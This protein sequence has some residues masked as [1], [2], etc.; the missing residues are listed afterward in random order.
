MDE[1]EDDRTPAQRFAD[2]KRRSAAARTE[3]AEFQAGYE[4]GLDGFQV[5]ACELLERGHSVLVAAPTGSGKTI[6]G[7]FAIHLALQG[8]TRAFYTTPIKALSNQ[9]FRDLCERHGAANVGLLTGDSVINGDAPVVV[10]TTEVL[11]NMLYEASSAIDTLSHVVMD[12]VH[13]LADRQRGAVWEEVILHL[14]ERITLVALSATVSNAEEFGAWLSQV[15]GG[16]DVIVEERRPVPLHQHVL[17]GRNLVDLFVHPSGEDEDVS[18]ASDAALELNPELVRRAQE[19]ARATRLND[20]SRGRGRGRPRGRPQRNNYVPRAAVLERLDRAGLLPAIVFVFS[21]RGCEEAVTSCLASGV[22]LISDADRRAVRAYVDKRC[23]EIPDQ[24]LAVLGYYEWREALERGVAAHH[25][26]MLPLFKEVVEELFCE[27]YIKAVFATETLA[28]GINMPARS[29]VLERL[30]K[31]NGSTHADVTAGEYT[32]LTG[33]AG[34]RGID[35]QGHAVTVWHNGID[36]QNLAGLA[37]TRTYPLKSSFRPSYN[38]AVNLIE[39]MGAKQARELLET[40]FAQYQAD[41]G[42]VGLANQI[43][44]H[45]QA[46][47]GYAES[48]ECHLGDF[49]EYAKLRQDLAAREKS[50]SRDSAARRRHQASDQLAA[51]KV[52]DVVVLA[53]GRRA[54]PALVVEAARPT[55]DEPRPSVLSLDRRVR[56]LSAADVPH[57]IES[58]ARMKVP[59]AFD[60]RSANW[61]RD[62]ARTLADRTASLDIKRPRRVNESAQ[63]DQEI[64]R[65]RR[66]LRA[67]PCHGCSDREAHARWAERHHKLAQ[68]TQQLRKR[69]ESRTNTIARQFDRVCAVLSDLGYLERDRGG[70][71]KVTPAGTLL[72]NL[73]ADQDLLTSE[74]LREG[75]WEGLTHA[76]LAGAAAALVFE[77]RSPDEGGVTVPI[78]NSPALRA[79]LE[80]QLEIADELAE[81]EGRHHVNFV[82]QPNAGFTMA[83]WHWAKGD[84][85]HT[86]LRESDLAP[87]DFVRWCR[88]LIDLMAQVADAADE[89]GLRQNARTALESLRRG[90]VSYTGVDAATP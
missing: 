21:R 49:S 76:E 50:L 62:L 18:D 41:S 38:M 24:D 53:S 60:P 45:E 7:E 61:R 40:S 39:R 70:Q 25:A 48:M 31:W 54:G 90:V 26:G 69:V 9:K 68:E 59:R 74:C 82:R 22:S 67:H 81:R 57:G 20:G 85:L 89:P 65:L 17:A 83:A 27:G 2:A 10:M 23:G 52:G 55:D 6:V 47:A 80:D 16:T 58:V 30:V 56:R 71:L 36:P 4:F 13:Y 8:G 87:G 66:E 3:L 33:R 32:Q 43:K 1:R 28:L 37:S 63:Q 73:Y 44:R 5:E 15:R 88:Q 12:E 46:L 64:E 14:P 42:I 86:V 75:V 84:P 51:L 72:G 11:R 34:R 79:A 77:S 19:D 78:P 29:V 35:T